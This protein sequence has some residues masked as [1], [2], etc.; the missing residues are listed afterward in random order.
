M[1]DS[2]E[3]ERGGGD[4]ENTKTSMILGVTAVI[5]EVLQPDWYITW[6]DYPLVT[7]RLLGF[8]VN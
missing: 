2:D 4:G 5:E 3:K 8:R 7:D 6:S 1:A